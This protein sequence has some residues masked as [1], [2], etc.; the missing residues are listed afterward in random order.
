[1]A[2]GAQPPEAFITSTGSCVCPIRTINGTR[3]G[4][5]PVPGPPTKCLTDAY[6]HLVDCDFVAPYQRPTSGLT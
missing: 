1:L 2:V 5:D 4:T 3:V 6:I